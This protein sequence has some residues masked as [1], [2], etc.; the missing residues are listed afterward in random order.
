MEVRDEDQAEPGHASLQIKPLA[1]VCAPGL[2]AGVCHGR[3]SGRP[4]IQGPGEELCLYGS[5][6]ASSVLVSPWSCSSGSPSGRTR[7]VPAPEHSPRERRIAVSVYRVVRRLSTVWTPAGAGW[8]RLSRSGDRQAGYRADP[9]TLAWYALRSVRRHKLTLLTR[10]QQDRL[11]LDA[12]SHKAG[13]T[14]SKAGAVASGER[15]D[16]A[17]G[18]YLPGSAGV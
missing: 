14:G 5:T 2:T 4:R 10:N 13:G 1:R 8:R 11:A 18:F 16:S 12:A 17:G 9:S 6:P 7:L 3:D 15:T